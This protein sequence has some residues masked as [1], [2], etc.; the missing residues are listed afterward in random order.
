MVHEPTH[1][2]GLGPLIR[3]GTY[4]LLSLLLLIDYVGCIILLEKR[5][6]CYWQIHQWTTLISHYW[7]K[8]SLFGLRN[9]QHQGS[10]YVTQNWPKNWIFLLDENHPIFFIHGHPNLKRIPLC[11]QM[12]RKL[13]IQNVKKWNPS[14]LNMGVQ[15]VLAPHACGPHILKSSFIFNF[16]R[17]K[18][19]LLLENR[20]CFFQNGELGPS[21]Q[22]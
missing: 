9:L 5:V 15:R 6:L 8:G 1:D 19:L 2:M 22:P 16:Y 7:S 17:Q 14:Q 10:R 21:I 18:K 11:C 3:C 4:L 12:C 13:F 20:K